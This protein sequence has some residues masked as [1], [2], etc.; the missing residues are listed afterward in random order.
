[1]RNTFYRSLFLYWLCIAVGGALAFMVPVVGFPFGIGMLLYFVYAIPYWLW[2]ALFF[3]RRERKFT[4]F[5]LTG[6]QFNL[7]VAGLGLALLVVFLL[8]GWKVLACFCAVL[9]YVGG[10][11]EIKDRIIAAGAGSDALGRAR[12][13]DFEE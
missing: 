2:F 4:A 1:M 9:V 13:R 10:E 6:R 3:R 5:N 7:A 11:M 8:L 12:R